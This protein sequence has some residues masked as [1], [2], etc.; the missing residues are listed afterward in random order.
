MIEEYEKG[1]IQ[2]LR[3][4]VKYI[5]NVGSCFYYVSFLCQ[6]KVL[7]LYKSS[8]HEQWHR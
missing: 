3:Q 8:D 2:R 4:H 5:D 1:N 7:H 6:P